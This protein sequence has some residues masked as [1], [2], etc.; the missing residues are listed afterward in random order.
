MVE[1]VAQ[2][3][4]YFLSPLISTVM[5]KVTNVMLC[6]FLHMCAHAYMCSDTN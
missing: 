4:D 1:I 2:Y 5:I 3:Y 6:V